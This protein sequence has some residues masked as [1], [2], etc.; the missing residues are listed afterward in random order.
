MWLDFEMSIGSSVAPVASRPPKACY[1]VGGVLLVY[2]ALAVTFVLVVHAN[3][4]EWLSGTWLLRAHAMCAGFGMMGSSI[5]SMRKYYRALITDSVNS[6]SGNKVQTAF[7]DFGWVYYYLTRPLVGGVLGALSFTLSF[8]GFQ[9]LAKPSEME[10]SNQ[11]R[12]LLFALAF[13]AGF[14]VSHVLDRLNSVSKQIFKADAPDI[15]ISPANYKGERAK[16]EKDDFAYEKIRIDR[17]SRCTNRYG[18]EHRY[19]S[20]GTIIQWRDCGHNF[21][22]ALI[23]S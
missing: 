13:V 23:D 14:S 3:V 19:A 10:I 2:L 9:A 16:P 7:W 8:V 20:E 21:N 1:L 11:G 5:A 17:P 6:R 12:Y 18:R 22:A 4:V 15:G